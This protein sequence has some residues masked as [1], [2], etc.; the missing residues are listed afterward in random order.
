M[1]ACA[2]RVLPRSTEVRLK[3]KRGTQ[4]CCARVLISCCTQTVLNLPIVTVSVS[5]VAVTIIAPIVAA[6]VRISRRAAVQLPSLDAS[7]PVPIPAVAFPSFDAPIAVKIQATLPVRPIVA[8]GSVAVI[9]V[10]PC[11]ARRSGQ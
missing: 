4:L 9:V 2:R 10:G 7:I 11:I 3:E 1:R 6:I 5:G 8:S